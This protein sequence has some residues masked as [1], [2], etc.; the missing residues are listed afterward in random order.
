MRDQEELEDRLSALVQEARDAGLST[1]ECLDAVEL[2]R[3][4]LRDAMEDEKED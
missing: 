1:S 3:E 4:I 2:Q